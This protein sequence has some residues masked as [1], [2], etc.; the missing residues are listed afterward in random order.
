MKNDRLKKPAKP[1]KPTTP[2]RLARPAA[3]TK[4][5]ENHSDLA[6]PAPGYR[7]STPAPSQAPAVKAPKLAAAASREAITAALE[8]EDRA[9]NIRELAAKL[10][11][12]SYDIDEL[13]GVVEKL[14]SEGLVSRRPGQ[15]IKLR[16][17]RLRE[18]TLEAVLNMNPRGF[19]FVNDPQGTGIFLPPESLSGAMHGDRV[20]VAIRRQ[21]EKGLEGAVLEVLGRAR[22]RVAGILRSRRGSRFVEPDDNRVRGPIVLTRAIDAESSAAKGNSGE[23][24]DL[25]VVAITRWPELPGENP[26]G[27]LIA[28]L[29]RPG[30]LEGESRK[31]LLVAGIE[32]LQ[33]DDVLAEAESFGDE[34]PP[35]LLEG[36]ENLEHVPF[37]AI[38]PDDAR[39]H[40][41]AVHVERRGA[42]GYKVFVAIA[43]VSAFVRPGT[44]ID[45]DASQ[46]GCTVYLPTRAIPMLPRVLSSN[47]CSLL[48]RKQRLCQ[49][50][51]VDLDAN[52]T[53]ES[54]RLF[55]A[56]MTGRALLTYGQA[57]RALGLEPS[58]GDDLGDAKEFLPNLEVAYEL[59]RKLRAKRMDRGALDF[60]LPEPKVVFDA[61][62]REP[63]DIVRRASSDGMRKAYQLVEE[64]M[65]LANECV[66]KELLSRELPAIFRNHGSPDPKKLERFTHFCETMGIAFA[67]EDAHDP[68]KVSELL[69]R[70]AA[71]PF[72]AVLSMLLLRSMKQAIYDTTNLGH[73]GLAAPAYLHFTSPIRR[74]PDLCA[75]RAVAAIIAGTARTALDPSKL[76]VAASQASTMERAAME[77]ERGTVDVYRCWIMRDRVG[78]RFEGTV[79]SCTATGAY[80]TLDAPFVDILLRIDS[81]GSDSYACDDEGLAIVGLR[82]GDRITIGDRVAVRLDDISLVRRQLLGTRLGTITRAHGNDDNALDAY[83]TRAAKRTK[84]RAAAK[85]DAKGANKGARAIE[86]FATGRPRLS[87]HGK[88]KPAPAATP[89]EARKRK[90]KKAAVSPK[91]SKTVRNAAKKLKKKG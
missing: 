13:D 40:D 74:Y 81:L 63:T 16:R 28:T 85:V 18:E 27:E 2:A 41:D 25:V 17:E 23:D 59:T 35:A 71:E 11:V 66:A 9:W 64:L 53:I 75:H 58:N 67:E 32:E 8:S 6:A 43:D 48:P 5:L 86:T 26:E 76:G 39:D 15:R 4:R 57:A 68:K 45:R 49:G 70:Y 56:I 73:F 91:A 52:G 33:P 80:V 65:L 62:S 14:V 78:E 51:E 84:E 7:L 83:R 19:G 44:A 89:D 10:G 20:K 12:P 54:V 88:G 61:V 22:T 29:G 47:L 42:G 1:A 38:D 34:V 90:P 21:T 37:L 55:S 77:V 82:S 50:V 24:G 30:T 3:L 36:R 72:G 60:E 69:R 79:S 87:V 31:L 46:R